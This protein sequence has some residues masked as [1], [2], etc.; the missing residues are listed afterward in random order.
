MPEEAVKPLVTFAMA[1]A[2]QIWIPGYQDH[3]V[4]AMLLPPASSG[5]DAVDRPVIMLC[6]PNGGLYEFHHLQMDWIKF[7][8]TRLDCHVLVYN[9]RG[10]GRCK[11]SPSPAMHN[12][13]GLAIVNY[14]KN[15]RGFVQ[16]AVHGESIGGLVATY[17]ACTSP[18]V[19]VLIADRTLAT[20]PALA[21]RMIARWAGT[22]VDW[23]MRWDTDNVQKYLDAPCAKILCSDPSDEI[24]LDGASLKSG[25]ALSVEL[26][27][28]TFDL[29]R[30]SVADGSPAPPV[31]PA[32]AVCKI[33]ICF[34]PCSSSVV[35]EAASRPV[36]GQPLT[37]SMVLRFSEAV[38]SVGRRALEHE[39]GRDDEQHRRHESGALEETEPCGDTSDAAATG[40]SDVAIFM[41]DAVAA[42]VVEIAAAPETQPILR[43]D[44]VEAS[45]SVAPT[46]K[47]PGELLAVVWMQLARLDGYCGQVLLQAAENGGHDKIRAWTASLLTWGGYMA[48]ERRRERSLEP[49]ERGGILIVPITI[50]EVH[51]VLQHLAEQHTS[52]KYDYDIDFVML[53]VEYL[54]DALQRR[55]RHLDSSTIEKRDVAGESVQIDKKTDSR[56]AAGQRKTVIPLL[57]NTEDA[58]L[59]CLLP[60][61]CGH[62]KNYEDAEKQALIGFLRHV[63]FIG[64]VK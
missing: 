12:L 30:Q 34:G 60:L 55:W 24:I 38:L 29:P 25:V 4:D 19:N 33:G 22:V 26:N 5:R 57:I 10:Y 16:I 63:G 47:F 52:F 8:T 58:R 36:V 40:S 14:L 35:S 15:E 17:V 27:D 13:D 62:N 48:P 28:K 50:A 31:S 43:A 51:A 44:L 6:N 20:V 53:M 49:F 11:G 64:S 18:H 41:D 21:Q 9:Y 61:R 2:E 59:G 3:Q 37:E 7:Y 56:A 1:K 45:A 46:L 32:K 23:V 54:D 39:T 42:S